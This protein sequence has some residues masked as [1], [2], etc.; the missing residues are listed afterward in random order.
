M[1]FSNSFCV[2]VK[3]LSLTLGNKKILEN[4]SFDIVKKSVYALVG[5]N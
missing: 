3:N 2:S 4:I 1:E 5:C